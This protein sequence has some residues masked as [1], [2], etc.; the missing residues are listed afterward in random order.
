MDETER[1]TTVVVGER[2]YAIPDEV[3]K[4]LAAA[5]EA[6]EEAERDAQ[7]YRILRNGDV[8]GYAVMQI[9]EAYERRVSIDGDR[10]DAL[11]DKSRK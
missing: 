10:L 8:K 3:A 4:A 5:L 7:R 9:S 1:L 11:L 2:C 6:K